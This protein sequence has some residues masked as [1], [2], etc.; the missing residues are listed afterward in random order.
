MKGIKMTVQTGYLPYSFISVLKEGCLCEYK[1]K[2]VKIVKVKTFTTHAIVLVASTTNPCSIKVVKMSL[3]E[4][5][6]FYCPI[7]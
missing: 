7:S 3:F 5:M 2:F 6:K 1:G 4:P